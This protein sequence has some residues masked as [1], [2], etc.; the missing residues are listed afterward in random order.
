MTL[1]EKKHA[2]VESVPYSA[3]WTAFA[4][5][6]AIIVLLL[7]IAF[8][9]MLVGPMLHIVLMALIITFVL[10]F[11]ILLLTRYTP[12]SYNLSVVVVFLLFLLIIGFAVLYLTGPLTN[13]LT[14]LA[15]SVQDI[16][17]QGI[18][19][20][21]NYTPAQ[22]WIVDPKT[23]EKIINLNFILSPLSEYAEGKN[24]GELTG[25]LGGMVGSLG[26]VLGF[27]GGT[28]FTGVVINILA[29]IFLLELPA[30]FEY[31]FNIIPDNYRREYA[32]LFSRIGHVW[33]GF[34]RGSLI[35]MALTAFIAWLQMTLMGIPHAMLIALIAGATT[36]IP[37]VGA[38]IAAIPIAIIPLTQGSTML[39]LDPITL[40]ILVSLIYQLGQ[41][42][43]WHA[44]I[45]KI[46]GTV[47]SLP[48]SLVI[49]AIAVGTVWWG[50]L[51]AFLAI[52]ILAIAREIV[53]YV[54][55]KI[56]GGDPYP[57]A[58][59]PVFLAEGAFGAKLP[60]SKPEDQS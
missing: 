52:P 13:S 41:L 20:L 12:L 36:L 17:K 57:G 34:L 24:L 51:G 35:S 43:L 11:P 50:L 9:A 37:I 23:N 58:A 45:P 21:Q 38:L 29:F 44:V 14:S 1:N 25:I 33:T 48:V 47:L 22:G 15:A 54:L 3:N 56:R 27:V 5:R 53:W 59:T 18:H 46:Y 2:E 10:I 16:V 6:T 19:F 55:S 28:L 26:G 4:R 30:G 8:V 31:V 32:I 42:I 49:I 60:D 40:T 39:N 7:A